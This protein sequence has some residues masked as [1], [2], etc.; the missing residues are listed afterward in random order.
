MVLGLSGSLGWFGVLG[1]VG[2]CHVIAPPGRPSHS[3]PTPAVGSIQSWE[4][5]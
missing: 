2:R 5:W 4:V 1:G 3:L